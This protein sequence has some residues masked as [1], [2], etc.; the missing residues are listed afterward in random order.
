M[1]DR[2]LGFLQSWP[3]RGQGVKGTGTKKRTANAPPPSA[4]QPMHSLALSIPCAHACVQ[5]SLNQ[6]PVYPFLG[7]HIREGCPSLTPARAH[8]SEEEKGQR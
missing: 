2:D 7:S 6:C 3:T 8:K 5:L 1:G 4:S